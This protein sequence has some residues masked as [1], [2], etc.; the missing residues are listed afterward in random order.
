MLDCTNCK[1]RNFEDCSCCFD[2]PENTPVKFTP[3]G[4]AHAML[5]GKTLKDSDG[6]EYFW[7]NEKSC[8]LRKF[9]GVTSMSAI[10]SGLFEELEK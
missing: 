5:V 10:F 7:S 1:T 3:K 8:F 9:E 2:D 4:A 6:A